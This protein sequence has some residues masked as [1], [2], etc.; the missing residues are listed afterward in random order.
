[1]KEGPERI[2]Y[3]E[4][5]DV[6][7]VHAAVKREHS[8]PTA[9][10]TPIPLWLTGLC[11][12]AVAWAGA[13]LGVFHGGFKGTV[14]NE[15]D[16]S[17]V[18]LFGAPGKQTGAAEAGAV[19]SLAQQGKSVYGQC[20][21]CHGGGGLGAPGQ[22]P[23]LAGSHFVTGSEKRVIA[24]LLKGVTG[25]ITVE[26]KAFNGAMPAWEAAMPD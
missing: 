22:F 14:Y 17:P 24:I 8:E 26:G 5:P 18:G 3:Q 21:G 9:E 19:L 15:Y 2:D 12:L 7:E 11:G 20:I 23:P 16:S 1:M 6:T 4:T 10:V 25:P 13:Y